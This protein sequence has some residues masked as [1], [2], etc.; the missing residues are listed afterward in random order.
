MLI[1][2]GTDDDPHRKHLHIVMNDPVPNPLNNN[3]LSVLLVSIS[4]VKAGM[5]SYDT[6]CVLCGGCHPSIPKD[7]YVV[8]SKAIVAREDLLRARIESG[9]I[10]RKADV[11]DAVF[12][13]VASGFT[14]SPHVAGKISS[15]VRDRIGGL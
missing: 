8:Y 2:S 6:T 1:E 7:S 4:S 9:E 3:R 12:E 13:R 5:A 11:S 10:K 15:F 14:F